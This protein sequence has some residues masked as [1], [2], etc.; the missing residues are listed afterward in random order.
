MALGFFVLEVYGRW[1]RREECYGDVLRGVEVH[2][3]EL[4]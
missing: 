4:A 1:A 3:D 2:L